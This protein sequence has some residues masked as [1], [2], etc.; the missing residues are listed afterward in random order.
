M[1]SDFRL[2]LTWYDRIAYTDV[3][4]F[5]FRLGYLAELFK[6][7]HWQISAWR[8]RQIVNEMTFSLK[9]LLNWTQDKL[10]LFLKE[11]LQFEKKSLSKNQALISTI[12]FMVFIFYFNSMML[13]YQP[14]CQVFSV[15]TLQ[16]FR[17]AAKM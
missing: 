9:K 14:S 3:L 7:F 2:I 10:F 16:K 12:F 4:G 11:L 8:Q 6:R 5:F 1:K 17:Q 13:L 15:K